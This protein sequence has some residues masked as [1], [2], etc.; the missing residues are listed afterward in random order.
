MNMKKYIT[1]SVR[2]IIIQ[3]QQILAGS[4]EGVMGEWHNEP[5]K[6]K[7]MDIE[8]DFEE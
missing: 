1:P 6:S 7:E 3:G 4:L 2:T 5:L 8:L